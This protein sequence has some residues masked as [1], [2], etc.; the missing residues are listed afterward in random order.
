MPVARVGRRA[1]ACGRAPRPSL[2]RVEGHFA[3]SRRTRSSRSGSIRSGASPPDRPPRRRASGRSS[4]S[5]SS[6][7]ARIGGAPTGPCQAVRPS[8]FDRARSSSS[9][10]SPDPDF[11]RRCAVLGSS[12]RT[13]L[14]VKLGRLRARAP[15]R[16]HQ[17]RSPRARTGSRRCREPASSRHKSRWEP[18]VPLARS[19][20]V[21][22]S[23]SASSAIFALNAASNFLRDFVIPRSIGCNRA[24]H[25][26]LS[27]WS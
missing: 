17:R 11:D 19:G 3:A 5:A 22:S 24:G 4:P 15:P 6:S 16:H 26:H 27:Q 7:T 1:A 12:P 8:L 21:A 9:A 13:S 14:G 10:S 2:L 25:S 20:T 18:P 23:R